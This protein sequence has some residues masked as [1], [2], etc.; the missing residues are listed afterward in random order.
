MNKME[1]NKEIRQ[2]YIPTDEEVEK[3]KFKDWHLQLSWDLVFHT[4]QWEWPFVWMPATFIRLN[5][6]NLCCSFCD[7]PYTFRKDMKEYYEAENCS[8][9]EVLQL[10]EE[11]RDAKDVCRAVPYN[12]VITGWEPLLQMNGIEELLDILPGDANIQ[13]E[14]N[15]TIIPT[16]KI[17]DKC[18]IICSPKLKSSN[19]I[20]FW[21]LT[22]YKE[23][24]IRAL[25]WKVTFK[26][27]CSTE[28]D[29]EEVVDF[30]DKYYIDEG[31]VYIMPEWITM[32]ENHKSFQKIIGKVLEYGLMV[33]PRLQNIIWEWSKR[34]V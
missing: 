34:W 9:I 24:M 21:S 25:V 7:T 12:I 23:E 19:N 20:V 29:I 3:L 2:C 6:C 18:E 17:F 27:V 15:G 33:T 4:I 26:F 10:I 31:N 8:I 11:A 16:K 14:T 28:D 32:E 22:K 5:K 30:M 1:R 13:I